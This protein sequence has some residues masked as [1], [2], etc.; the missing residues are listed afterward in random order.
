MADR[1]IGIVLRHLRQSLSGD[2]GLSDAQ[3]LERFAFTSDQAAF[4]VL[5][6]RH[7]RLVFGVCRRVLHDFH[8]AEDAFQA[9]FLALARKGRGISRR[10]AV[11]CWLHKVAFRIAIMLRARRAKVA[12]RE[13]PMAVAEDIA[14]PSAFQ[15]SAEWR[16]VRAIIDEEVNRLPLQFRAP[17]IICYF[18]GKTVDEAAVQLGCP[19]GTVASRLARARERLG[20]RL[21]GR[22][23]AISAVA[24][25]AGFDQAGVLAAPLGLLQTTVGAIKGWASG[26]L[27]ASTANT[28]K[29]FA[30]TE[31]VL[32]AMFIKKLTTVAAVIF[33]CT[34]ALFVGSAVGMRYLSAGEEPKQSA[35]GMDE[36]QAQPPA[37]K[38]V[39][40]AKVQAPAAKQPIEG[41]FQFVDFAGRLQPSSDVYVRS[42]VSGY[43]TSVHCQTGA[44]VKKG[45]VL[46]QLDG[47]AYREAEARA[48][49]NLNLARA[50]LTLSTEQ[51]LTAKSAFKSNA[52][53]KAD[54]DKAQLALE[55]D[56]AALKLAELDAQRAKRDLEATTI[57]APADGRVGELLA[58]GSIV[59]VDKTLLTTVTL[60][61]PMDVVFVMDERNFQRY[62]RLL[63]DKQVGGPGSPLFIGLVD[64]EGFPRKGTLTSFGDRFNEGTISVQGTLP[65]PEGQLL[66]GMS[67]RVRLPFGKE[68]SPPK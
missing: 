31:E 6:R 23:L 30:I 5:V 18:E 20:I 64:E 50:Q 60:L 37:A 14:A 32:G 21:A 44:T 39:L 49:T 57:K 36:L 51:L 59:A 46:F 47:V 55:R 35:S 66:P 24:L 56:T 34:G 1:D 15:Q 19:R 27:A 7:E 62:Q 28:A 63:R 53:S 45:D 12:S 67:V 43:L 3:L 52:M 48:A 58:V 4:K 42:R 10:E 25:A 9:T 26:K 16:E 40:A 13:G 22:G 8:D 61:E 38:K 17:I 29:V 11:A 41:S 65:N 2:S 33:A 54:F 68:T